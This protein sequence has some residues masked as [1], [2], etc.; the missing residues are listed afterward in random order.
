MTSF[1]HHLLKY[2]FVSARSQAYT[3]RKQEF[4]VPQMME[5]LNKSKNWVIKRSVCGES[6]INGSGRSI[7]LCFGQRQEMQELLQFVYGFLR[8]PVYT[9][10]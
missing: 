8:Y 7:I 9:N 3:F 1:P 6:W 4:K 5:I 10:L 2:S